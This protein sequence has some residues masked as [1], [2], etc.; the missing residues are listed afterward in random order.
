MV[1]LGAAP[2]GT[3]GGGKGLLLRVQ[4]PTCRSAPS[5]AIPT[6]DPSLMPLPLPCRLP[7]VFV[8]AFLPAG[9]TVQTIAFLCHLRGKGVLGP[10]MVLGP[11]STLS[12]WAAEFERWAPGFP[13]VLYHGNKAE[14]AALRA[15]HLGEGAG[16]SS[17]RLCLFWVLQG[18]V[19]GGGGGVLSGWGVGLLLA[20]AAQPSLSNPAGPSPP[21]PPSP[22][23]SQHQG[24]GQV[25][26]D[27]HLVRD[28]DRRHQGHGAAQ[29]EVRGHD[30]PAEA[31][32]LCCDSA[33]GCARCTTRVH[34]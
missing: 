31:M 27:H 7:S 19:A 29:L 24:D 12:N 5:A 17:G 2:R 9:K 22:Y 13:A 32:H 20:L 34:A 16:R 4:R 3:V 10:F 18:G 6:A 14:R 15:K 30:E 8:P 21:Q 23:S 11:L 28:R 26:C 1:K 25:P 33:W